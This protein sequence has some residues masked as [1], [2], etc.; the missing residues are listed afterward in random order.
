MFSL[1]PPIFYYIYNFTFA[2]AEPDSEDPLLALPVLLVDLK[3]HR[4]ILLWN[5]QRRT[6]SG[7]QGLF[8]E[9]M[10]QSDIERT[11][12]FCFGG[13]HGKTEKALHHLCRKF[14]YAIFIKF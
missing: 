1:Y 13:K 6:T 14:E 5:S 4:E 10:C 12:H 7:I 3:E 2:F 8:V 11:P 9:T